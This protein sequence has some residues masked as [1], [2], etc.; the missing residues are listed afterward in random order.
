MPEHFEA[1]PTPEDK[2]RILKERAAKLARAPEKEGAAGS[3]EILEITLA[4][5]RYG[6][7]SLYVRE[8]YPL[9]SFT[10]VPCTP[11][12]VLGVVNIRGQILPVIDIGKFFDLPHRELT[13]LSRVVVLRSGAA[14][15]GLLADE[16]TG[17]RLVAPG[18]IQASL[19]AVTGIRAEYLKGV[20]GDSL[21]VL[22]A[23]RILAD[24]AL[25]IDEEVA[26]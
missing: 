24:K 21:A 5:E 25:V 2:K 1:G 18:E 3:L 10:P 7:E 8:V 16:V 22:D 20:T 6:L 17:V 14:E 23:V 15:F 11:A 19:H 4:G 12:F 13:E 26:G 9:K